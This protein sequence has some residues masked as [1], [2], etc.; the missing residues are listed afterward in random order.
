MVMLRL[1]FSATILTLLVCPAAPAFAEDIDGLKG[2]FA[3]NWQADPEKTRCAA[4]DS[5]L[6]SSF[7][8]KDYHCELDAV[9]NT[10]SGE[11]AR[12]CTKTDGSAEYLIF[13]DEKSCEHE[14]QTQASNRP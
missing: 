2:Q 5:Q 8:S 4:L 7:K 9:E 13:R 12:T 10:A 14:R 3:F 11:P 1:S 6:L